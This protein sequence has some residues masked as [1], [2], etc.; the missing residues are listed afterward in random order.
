MINYHENVST[1]NRKIRC[2]KIKEAR[3]KQTNLNL[4]GQ[5]GK[6]LIYNPEQNIHKSIPKEDIQKYIDLGWIKGMNPD[7]R[8]KAGEK[9]K[10]KVISEDTRK[11][12]SQSHLNQQKNNKW[13]NNGKI[14]KRV[15]KNILDNYLSNGWVLGRI[16]C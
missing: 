12:L 13:I 8:K 4:Q 15:D 7:I 11:K 10:G 14:N 2:D 5:K 9:Q 3:L 16:K 6:T 1:E